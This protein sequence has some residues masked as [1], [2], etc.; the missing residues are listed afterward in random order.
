MRF[1]DACKL[2]N[3]DEVRIR[4]DR[5]PVLANPGNAGRTCTVLQVGSNGG[6]V[7]VLDVIAPDGRI[8][9]VTHRDIE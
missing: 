9:R 6:K 3:D 7:C 2:R 1:R 5:W 8:E 4:S